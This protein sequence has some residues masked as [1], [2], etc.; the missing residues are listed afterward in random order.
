MSCRCLFSVKPNTLANAY[1]LTRLQKIA[2]AALQNIPCTKSPLQSTYTTAT[3]SRTTP[4]TITPL[5]FHINTNSSNTTSNR[6]HQPGLLPLPSPPIIPKP[7]PPPNP[8][9]QWAIS[10]KD[11]DDRCA[12]GL[13]FWCDKKFVPGHHCKKKQL[14]VM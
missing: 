1:S 12:K 8:K 7:N 11:L 5:Q 2:V 13:C 3:L 10:N 14:Y 6:S 4:P 9:F